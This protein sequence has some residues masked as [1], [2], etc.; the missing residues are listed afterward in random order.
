MRIPLSKL[1]RAFPELDQFSDQ[2]CEQFVQRARESE[3]YTSWKAGIPFL[4]VGIAASTLAALQ[5]GLG[6]AAV[7]LS[8]R[9][10]G[11]VH[12]VDIFAACSVVTWVLGLALS[13]LIARDLVL[14]RFLKHAIWRRIERMRCAKCQ[15]SLLGQREHDGIVRCPECGEITTLRLLG[16]NS[17][18]DLLPPEL[19]ATVT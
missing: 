18:A 16:L 9:M 19:H 5:C 6:T 8:Q 2:Q 17:E 10:F 12:G 14:W 11:R 1:Y 13:G 15:Y 4:A 7:Q 3:G